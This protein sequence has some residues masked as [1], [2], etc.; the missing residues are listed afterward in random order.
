MPACVPHRIAE[1]GDGKLEV[2]TTCPLCQKPH[3]VSVAATEYW[4]WMAGI[5]SVQAAFPELSNAER[6]ML[7]TGT[8]G[9]CWD[10]MFPPEDDDQPD[11]DPMDLQ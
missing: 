4:S 7:I 3:R 10:E 6:E 1:V 9:P 5:I 11:P 2:D 8:C